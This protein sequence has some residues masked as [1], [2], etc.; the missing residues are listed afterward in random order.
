MPAVTKDPNAAEIKRLLPIR[1]TMF[2]KIALSEKFDF[3]GN[4]FWEEIT[5]VGYNP[6]SVTLEAV[7]AIK[8]AS[9][10]S[11]GLCSAGSKEF[12]RFFVDYG[13]GFEDI[14]YTSF[15]AHDIPDVGGALHPIEYVVR[16]A[17]PD[18]GH[19]RCCNTAVIPTVRA[20]LSWNTPPSSDPNAL[21][22]FGNRL[23]ARI[24]L[25]PAP[26]SLICL[27]ESGVLQKD[28]AILK[29]LDLQQPLAKA[30]TVSAA[31][32]AAI[33]PPYR[34]AKVPDHRLLAPALHAILGKKPAAGAAISLSDIKDLKKLNID[35]NAVVK[36]LASTSADTAFEELTC[37]GLETAADTLGAV[38]RIKQPF[39]YSGD[40][41]HDG[42]KEYVAFW[43]DWNNDGVFDEYLGTATAEVHDLDKAMP[44]DGVRYSVSLIS[45]SIVQHLRDCTSP[46]I[47]RVR[48]V[49]SWATP[50][51]TTDPNALD[52]WG[53]R[54]DVHVQIRPGTPVPGTEL[55][56]LIYRVGSVALSDISTVTH[57]AFPSTVLTGACGAGPMD[58]PWGGSVMIQG[59]LYNTGF[60]GSV[61]FRVRYKRHA[62]A[63][64]DANWT[65][66]TFSQSF[67]FMYPLL[68]PPDVHV[69]LIAGT[70]P[71]CGSG[72]FDYLEN[73][74]ASPPIFERDNRIADWNTG[75]LEGEFDLRLEYRRTIDPPGFFH[76]SQV[77]TIVLHNYQMVA[78]VTATNVI[79]FSKDLDLVID[80]G[81][82][83]S[84]V[85]G[86]S[87]QGHLRVLDPYF[88]TWGFELQPATHTHGAAPVPA[89]RTNTSLADSGDANLQ[90]TLDTT[91]MDKC[92]Y[93][94]ILRG[95]DRTI[96]NNNGG[97]V[98][99]A[100]K[101]VGFSVV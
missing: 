27:I 64:I 79:D 77:V 6:Q 81:D 50:P 9:G 97:S 16:L 68:T 80:G 39:G 11:G 45:P 41:C 71:G 54:I 38:I 14:G 86:G 2:L 48:A 3:S 70:E 17:L 36:A 12:V 101:A 35:L 99:G 5:C 30:K 10:Y 87:F 1:Q 60:P 93:A 100:S 7:V 4:T 32:F 20:V 76:T 33:A 62:D 57:L 92:G 13:A 67:V 72:W 83:H 63:D 65:P 22:A 88:W 31:S 89:C 90:W 24:Q 52:F 55:T 47:V 96:L 58:R 82:C 23:D 42:S 56:D 28:A 69:S 59:R 61:R 74:L 91:P 98:H 84:Y 21:N 19:R 78:S 95:Y 85:K 40:L 8:Q 51:S 25:A 49:L 66:V 15:N 34:A 37:V 44:A 53:N 26:F 43:A 73:P 18:T 75:S 94:L 29:G 46:N